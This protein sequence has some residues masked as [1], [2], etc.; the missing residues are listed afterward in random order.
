MLIHYTSI[1]L[2]STVWGRLYLK[3]KTFRQLVGI[4]HVTV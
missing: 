3:H 2:V 4:A 1:M